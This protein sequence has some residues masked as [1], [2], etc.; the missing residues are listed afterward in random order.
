MTAPHLA[1]S[2]RADNLVF[3]SGQLAFNAQGVIEGDVAAQTLMV[4]ARLQQILA[5]HDAGLDDIVK[6]TVFITRAEDFA[7]FNE[8]YAL[9]FGAH[10]PT[11]STVIAGLAAANALVEIEAI[12]KVRS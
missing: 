10:K 7:A 1:P 9:A 12:A 11:R 6:T 4:I 2:V 3:T 8:A 5:T